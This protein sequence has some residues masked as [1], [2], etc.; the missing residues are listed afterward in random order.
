MAASSNRPLPFCRKCGSVDIV[1]SYI[2]GQ[3]DAPQPYVFCPNCAANERHETE[4]EA[5]RRRR[6]RWSLLIYVSCLATL[7]LLPLPRLD[8]TLNR[9][10]IH[11]TGGRDVAAW[12]LAVRVVHAESDRRLNRAITN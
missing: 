12:L 2:G 5:Q 11:L 1:V 10:T 7:A 9:L 6:I 4:L 3:F 8:I